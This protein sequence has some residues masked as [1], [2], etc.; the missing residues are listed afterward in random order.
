[1]P[2]DVF[3]A[4]EI[5]KGAPGRLEKMG[6]AGTGAAIY[7]DYAHTPDALETVLSAVRP[8]VAG[9][10]H[11]IFG[12]GGDRDKGKRPLMGL[13]ARKYADVVFITDDNPRGEDPAQ[14]RKEALAGAP[15]ARDIGDRAEAIRVA[16]AGL[17]KDDVL[18]IAGKGHERGQVVGDKTI[19]FS[20]REEAVRA[21]LATGGH[22]GSV[23]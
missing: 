23:K 19:P 18:V 10:L 11:V 1:M 20:D 8:H 9:K 2:A 4:L 5:L 3:K 6:Y 21:A 12:C 22:A 7:V 14:I 16:V 15:D 17:A 13:A